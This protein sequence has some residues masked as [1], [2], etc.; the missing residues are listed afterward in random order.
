MSI[1]IWITYF[2]LATRWHIVGRL[3]SEM[4]AVFFTKSMTGVG[5]FVCSPAQVRKLDLKPCGT[6]KTARHKKTP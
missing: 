6:V 2:G 4:T 1:N 5:V 3:S